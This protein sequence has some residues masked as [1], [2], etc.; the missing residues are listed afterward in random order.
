MGGNDLSNLKHYK[1]TE[2]EYERLVKMKLRCQKF[3]HKGKEFFLIK[4][5]INKKN[6]T[7]VDKAEK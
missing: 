7:S 1:D 6:K 4:V 2:F 5:Q 3:S